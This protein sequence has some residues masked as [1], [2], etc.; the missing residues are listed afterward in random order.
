MTDLE[1][2]LS[3]MCS[4]KERPLA[5]LVTTPNGLH[6]NEAGTAIQA[7]YHVYVEC[8]IATKSDPLSALIELAD[9]QKAL[10]FTGTQRRLEAPFQYLR[11]VVAERYEFGE[12]KR[13]HLRFAARHR[14]ED[15]RRI[16]ELSG[17]GVITGSGYH[18]LDIAAWLVNSTGIQI[19]EDLRGVVRL[20]FD[21]PYSSAET[22]VETEA[23]GYMELPN[24]ILLSFDFS[25]NAPENTIFEQVELYDQ[26]FTRVSLIR[27]QAVRTP[28]PA[29]ITHQLPNGQVVGIKT[30]LGQGIRAEA[31]RF[32]DE[33]QNMEPLRMFIEAVRRGFDNTLTGHTLEA[34]NSLST[35]HL[36]REIYRL[37]SRDR[38]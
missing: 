17:G 9:S 13:I 35:W 33:A 25:Y 23:F 28:L 27:D 31:I 20:G 10:L 26:D 36:I 14:L 1:D 19:S 8:P 34:W 37:A 11:K 4:E 15:W 2:A 12:L 7:G 32:A 22:P 6:F 24:Q 16:P 38:C 30:V 5:V 18:L 29:T 21:E 3:E